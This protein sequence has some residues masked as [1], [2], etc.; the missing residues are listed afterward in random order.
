M[1]YATQYF[2]TDHKQFYLDHHNGKSK[3]KKIRIR[4]Y[5]DSNLSFLEIKKKSHNVTNKIRTEIE[6]LQEHLSNDAKVFLLDHQEQTDNL[7]A[8][9]RNQFKR[10]SLVNKL[11]NERVT[12]DTDLSYQSNNGEVSFDG[13]A[14]IEV[15]QERLNRST[16]ICQVLKAHRSYAT[17]ISKYCLGIANLFADVKQNRFKP[18]NLYLFSMMTSSR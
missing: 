2:D 3:R 6:D 8:I 7:H 16:K 10:I 15:K 9:L 18:M 1:Q 11:I 17:S 4:K 14:I 5:V 13:I 12:I